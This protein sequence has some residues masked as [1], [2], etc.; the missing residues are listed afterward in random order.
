MLQQHLLPSKSMPRCLCRSD[1]LS[2][3]RYGGRNDIPVCG[4]RLQ[5]TQSYQQLQT[6]LSSCATTLQLPKLNRSWL[7]ERLQKRF[8]IRRWHLESFCNKIKRKRTPIL[9][10]R[11]SY[12]CRKKA[13]N[14][15]Q[16]PASDIKSIFGDVIGQF[17]LE[18]N[19]WSR[20]TMYQFALVCILLST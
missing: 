6:I 17:R 10:R 1:G 2:Q 9:S 3:D 7:W 12:L 19:L 11:M 16:N 13:C 18:K 15:R 8:Y 5:L 14:Q 4:D 20:V